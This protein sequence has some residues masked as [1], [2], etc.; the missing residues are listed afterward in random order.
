M[1]D[2]T[3][4]DAVIRDWY[5]ACQSLS[6]QGDSFKLPSKGIWRRPANQYYAIPLYRL[7][8]QATLIRNVFGFDSLCSAAPTNQLLSCRLK[9]CQ[10]SAACRQRYC[11]ILKIFFYTH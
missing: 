6:F 1:P 2:V 5:G 9:L 11:R 4:L 10:E 7:G 8:M 3:S